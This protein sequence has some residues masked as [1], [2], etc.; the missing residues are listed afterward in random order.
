MMQVLDTERQKMQRRKIRDIV[1]HYP[2][3]VMRDDG[4]YVKDEKFGERKIVFLALGGSYAYGTNV[5]TSDIDVRG[6]A[7]RSSEEI[8]LGEDF[9]Q[10]TDVETDTVIYSFD[11]MCKLLSMCNPNTIEILGVRSEDILYMD[12]TGQKLLENKQIFLSKRAIRSFGGYANAQLHRLKNRSVRGMD[13]SE[14]EKHILKSIENASILLKERY[15]ESGDGIRLYIDEAVNQ[16]MDTEIFMD[17]S[18]QHYPLRDYKDYWAEMNSIVKSYKKIGKRN[19]NA[20]SRNK[21]SKH[22]MHLI[23]LYFMLFDIMER[24]VVQ[25]YRP[26]REFLLQIRNGLFFDGDIPKEELFVYVDKLEKRAEYLEEYTALPDLPD[27]EKIR[28]LRMDVN[29]MVLDQCL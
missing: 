15:Q 7:L 19:S 23:R 18:L 3:F 26:E 12:E 27:E 2:F 10:F 21:C 8:L 22:C 4:L 28:R 1:L 29:R 14:R 6:I 16:D 17:V 11:K 9:E 25:T 24:Q 5:E 20:F 13:D